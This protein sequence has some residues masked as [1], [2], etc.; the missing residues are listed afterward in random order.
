MIK[1]GGSEGGV[2]KF[3]VGAVLS[4]VSLY[5]F[6]DSVRVS[7]DGA[8]L[9]SGGMRRMRGGGG[10]GWGMWDTTSMGI[11]FFPFIIGVI[12]LFYD[13]S[14]K[15]AWGL[16]WV[17]LAVIVVEILSRVRFVMNTKTSLLLLMFVGFAAGAGLMLQSYR[18]G[19]RS[20]RQRREDGRDPG[21]GDEPGS[22]GGLAGTPETSR[23]KMPD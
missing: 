15:W 11:V 13:A 1:P 12:A 14:K 4:A 10:G 5:F 22:G 16:T 17:G 20:E 2:G 6:F 3:V 23:E 19:N 7:T 21:L 9:F 18:D 8:G